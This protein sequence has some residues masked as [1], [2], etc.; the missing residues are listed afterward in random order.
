[1]L[2]SEFDRLILGTI[3]LLLPLIAPWDCV[4]VGSFGSTASVLVAAVVD[5]IFTVRRALLDFRSGLEIV[6]V[7]AEV[8]LGLDFVSGPADEGSFTL[9][10]VVVNETFFFLRE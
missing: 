8:E 9:D 2:N 5:P 3:S 1:M 4:R 7:D 10:V 6:P